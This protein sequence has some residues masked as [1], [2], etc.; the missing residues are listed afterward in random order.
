MPPDASSPPPSPGRRLGRAGLLL[1]LLAP[2]LVYLGVLWSLA[3]N[4]PT[5]DDFFALF[6][7]LHHWQD[8]AREGGSALGLLFEQFYSHRIPFTRVAVLGLMALQGHCDLRLLLV[9]AW[10]GWLLLAA[11]LLA[12]RRAASRDCSGC[13]RSRCC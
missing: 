6:G 1:L 9:L 2:A 3:I 5:G 8:R 7:F 10:A 4:V 12:T 11:S 13:C